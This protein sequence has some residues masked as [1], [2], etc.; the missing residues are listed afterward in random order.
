[1]NHLAPLGSVYQAGTLSG[2]PLV[3]A[4]GLAALEPL[5]DGAA[6]GRLEG[7]GGLLVAGLTQAARSA[8]VAERVCVQSAG[9]ML[10]VFFTPGPITDYRS[11][12]ASN[13]KAYA[14]FFHAMLDAG[15]YL[16]PS[17]FEAWFISL[18][19]TEKDIAAT[20]E[21]AGAA[22]KAAAGKM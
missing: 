5:C 9:S 7:L 2:N 4:A 10:A 15:V 18:A 6:Y 12:T 16:P 14:A 21:A 11:A 13:T 19:H 1:M 20:G 8:D 17:Q 3:M 22:F